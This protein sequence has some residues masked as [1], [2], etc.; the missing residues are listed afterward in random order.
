[1]ANSPQLKAKSVL[2]V[3]AENFHFKPV[4]F[5]GFRTVFCMRFTNVFHAL[6]YA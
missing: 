2:I 4:E 6:F 1:M 5:E 3:K